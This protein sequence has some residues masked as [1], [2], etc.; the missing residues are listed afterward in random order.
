MEREPLR[1]ELGAVAG[2]ATLSLDGGLDLSSAAY[3]A[4]RF[5]GVVQS[6][7]AHLDVDLS[8]LTYTDSV[9]LSVFV[10]AHFQCIDAGIHL[11]FLNPNTFL[12]ELVTATGL[13]EVLGLVRTDDLVDA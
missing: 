2:R 4:E 9:G 10:T 6:R 12:Q 11:R 13:A 7:P 8:Q 5:I 1:V 3:F